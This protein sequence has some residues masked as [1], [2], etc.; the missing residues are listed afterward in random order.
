MSLPSA[1]GEFVV[2]VVVESRSARSTVY[3]YSKIIHA[4]ILI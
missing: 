3:V 4:S 2:V 1:G